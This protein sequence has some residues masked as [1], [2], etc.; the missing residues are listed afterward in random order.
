[1]K[2]QLFFTAL[3]LLIT[4]KSFAQKTVDNDNKS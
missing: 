1:M 2:H 4:F 3:M